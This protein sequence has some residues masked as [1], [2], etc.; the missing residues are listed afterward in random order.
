[1]TKKKTRN[2][3][4]DLLRICA[5]LGVAILHILGHGGILSNTVSGKTFAAAWFLEILAYPAV[6]CFVLISGFVG[7]REEK[8]CPRLKNIISLFLTVVLYGVS[9][10]LIFNRIHP[11]EIGRI[12]M[13]NTLIPVSTRQYW[14]FSSYF[15][16]FL[17][18][19]M[20]N[21]F[22]AKADEKILKITALSVI[23]LFTVPTLFKEPFALGGGYSVIWFVLLYLLGAIIKK[24]KINERVSLLT[25]LPVAFLMYTFTFV[26]KILELPSFSKNASISEFLTK[27]DSK[28]ISYCSPMLIIA[29]ICL[30]CIF[31]KIKVP[32]IFH[33]IIGFFSQTA[34]SVYLIHDNIFTRRYAISGRFAVWAEQS[35]TNLAIKVIAAAL[36]IF[37][38]CSAIDGI[39]LLVFKFFRVDKL[40]ILLE[41]YI[42][43][44]CNKFFGSK[45]TLPSEKKDYSMLS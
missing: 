30:L 29:S 40:C 44:I 1:M 43:R 24:Q 21:L 9:I 38:I 28:F 2:Y 39:R 33:I 12:D 10:V 41:K 6:N 4:I 20:M 45:K 17:L 11:A 14:F 34:F 22:V 27:H 26:L 16:M 13:L 31:S 25:A 5:M 36:I 35:P 15:G 7:F 8:Y 19:P 23:F 37:L 3:G 32:K 42:K 18:S